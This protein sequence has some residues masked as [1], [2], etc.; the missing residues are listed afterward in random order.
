MASLPAD[1][2]AELGLGRRNYLAAFF[3]YRF[4]YVSVC[5]CCG[6]CKTGKPRASRSVPPKDIGAEHLEGALKKSDAHILH[7]A[8][9]AECVYLY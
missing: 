6:G 8:S 3:F 2:R 1:I 7:Q 5:K 9:E 4:K